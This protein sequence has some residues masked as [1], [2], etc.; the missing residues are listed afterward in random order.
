MKFFKLAFVVAC[1]MAMLLTGC[2]SDEDIAKKFASSVEALYEGDIPTEN[3]IQKILDKY[4][5][6]TDEQKSLVPNSIRS[7]V[8]KLESVDLES[9]NNLQDSIDEYLAT[10]DSKDDVDYDEIKRILDKYDR[11]TDLEKQFINDYDKIEEMIDLTDHDKAGIAAV[12]AVKTMLKNPSS[13]Q[14][15]HLKAKQINDGYYVVVEYNAQNGFGGYVS[16]TLCM[17]VDVENGHFVDGGFITGSRFIFG[18]DSVDSSSNLLAQ[19]YLVNKEH[20]EVKLDVE[21]V[22]SCLDLGLE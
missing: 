16:K 2:A 15:E 11:C 12:K 10:H 17:D 3:E 14:V 18:S 4:E 19:T 5:K 9:L 21:K 7:E 8:A 22:M 13:L 20:E 6:M 1:S